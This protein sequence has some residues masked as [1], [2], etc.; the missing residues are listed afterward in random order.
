MVMVRM[1]GCCPAPAAPTP[2][3]SATTNT[4]ATLPHN[5]RRPPA[6]TVAG[7]WGAAKHGQGL[8]HGVAAAVAIRG[9]GVVPIGLCK[10]K[11]RGRRGRGRGGAYTPW[12][13]GC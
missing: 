6:A 7:G 8:L 2:H 4:S 11:R 1:C 13:P 10:G 9:R 3:R 12:S 5:G